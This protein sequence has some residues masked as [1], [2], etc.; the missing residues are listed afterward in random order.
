VTCLRT[1]LVFCLLA[2]TAL[3]AEVN[4]AELAKRPRLSQQT[5]FQIIRAINAEFAYARKLFPQGEKG[6]TLTPSGVVTPSD[7]VLYRMSMARGAAARLGE[8]IQITDVLIGDRSI[9][10]EINGGPVKKAKWYQHITIVGMGGAASAADPNAQNAHGSFVTLAFKDHVPEMTAAELKELL[11]P[12]FDFTV[13]SASQAYVDAL[14]PKVREA[15]KNHQVLVGMNR[16]MV[17]HAKGRPEHKVRERE[18]GVDYEEWI[19]GEPPQEVA[20]VR[21]VGDEVVQLELMTVNGEKIV[22]T[23]KEVDLAKTAAESA[24]ATGGQGPETSGQPAG[25]VATSGTQPAKK[26]AKAPTLRRPGEAAPEPSLQNPM[27]RPRPGE[28]TPQTSPLPNPP[29]PK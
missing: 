23:D 5:R 17:M 27:P 13:K 1:S 21:F 20:F 16:E 11:T 7:Q 28:A 29:E 12:V 10:F 6:L 24:P 22:R 2:A 3:P 9:R 14:P 15:I 19:Y 26:P 25:S 18:K 4:P 8:R